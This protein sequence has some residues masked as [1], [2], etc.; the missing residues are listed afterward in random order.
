L[1]FF[2]ENKFMDFAAVLFDM[3]GVVIDT[4]E[5][6]VSYWNNLAQLH[7]VELTEHIYEQ[8][9]YGTPAAYTLEKVFTTLTAD[10]RQAVLDD[11][12]IYERQLSYTEI[13]GV[14]AFLRVLKLQGI[15][16]ALVTSA[17][18]HKVTD[19]FRQLGLE[20]LFSALVTADDIPRGKPYPDC[21]LQAAR[22]LGKSPDRCIVFEDAI[23]GVKAAVSAG[24]TCIGVRPSSIAAPLL[25]NG[26]RHVIPNFTDVRTEMGG[27]L[28]SVRLRL[29]EDFS[30]RVSVG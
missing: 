8:Q 12:V 21:Y 24:T 17:M 30:L 20:D 11:I 16:T 4:H 25:Q 2:A 27:E 9:I 18:P 29:N 5:S 7:G 22:H 23:S 15:P 14:T 10:Q 3:D 13:D 19:V 6:V 26:A 28:G 1:C